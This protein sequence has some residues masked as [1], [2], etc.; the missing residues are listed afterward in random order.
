MR[1]D[2][3]QL[4]SGSSGNDA[5]SAGILAV[6]QTFGAFSETNTLSNNLMF[7]ICSEDNI[8]QAMRT[9]R[10]NKGSPGIDGMTVDECVD[11]WKDHGKDIMSQLK[12]GKYTPQ[13]IKGVQI[14][15]PGGGIRQLG[16]P[17]V[18]DRVIQQAITQ[19]LEPLFKV[20]P[21]V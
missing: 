11:Y 7:E 12:N 21:F 9:V 4:S 3:T 19:I 15:K 6:Q 13:A 5:V 10:R 18:V 2:Q 17:T 1:R 8:K 16:I 20:T 14:P